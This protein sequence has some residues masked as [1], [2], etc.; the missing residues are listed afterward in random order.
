[1][2]VSDSVVVK[3]L[4]CVVQYRINDSDL[5]TRVLD[6]RTSI[7]THERG[8]EYDGEIRGIHSVGGRSLLD[9]IQVES[10]ST[11]GGVVGVGKGVDNGME[12]VA[13]D[14]VVFVP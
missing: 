1:M 14:N 8:T 5:P 12:G 13:A 11:E 3:N 10:K 6:V 4:I 2:S 7:R 9:A